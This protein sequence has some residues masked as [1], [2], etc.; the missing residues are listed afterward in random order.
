MSQIITYG[1]PGGLPS[2]L[3]LTGNVGGPVGPTAGNINVVGG[4]SIT[5]TGNP[6]TSTLTITDAGGGMVWT[7]TPAD[8]D[9]ETNISG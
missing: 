5:V 8:R 2:V 3:T 7:V 9:W 1:N 6:G 4:G